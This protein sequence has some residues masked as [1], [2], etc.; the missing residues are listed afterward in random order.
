M[1]RR[2]VCN[3]MFGNQEFART[4][5]LV[6]SCGFAGIEIAPYTLSNVNGYF[7]TSTLAHIRSILE[8]NELSFAGFHWL[9][10]HP[11]GMHI[12]SSDPQARRRALD[13]LKGLLFAAGELGGG[14]LILG[15]PKQ[16]SVSDATPEEGM[17]RL[18]GFLQEATEA[19][20]EANSIIC[21]EALPKKESNVM[22]TL[23]EA[24]AMV[25]QIGNSAIQSM[26]DFH[27][28]GDETLSWHELLRE[29]MPI[30]R[31][32]HINRNDGGHPLPGSEGLFRAAFKELAA[33]K[34]H[35]WVSLEIFTIPADPLRVLLETRDFLDSVVHT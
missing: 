29:Y 21:L 9:F 7:S 16:R 20:K 3:E 10:A 5:A 12:T 8:A 22:N 26:F 30:I 6:K 19:A 34:Y 32:V 23:A 28:C 11:E 31:H 17:R 33:Q 1:M 35:G 14:F 15:S 18:V 25:E 4:C 13:H 27:N 2:A 24:R